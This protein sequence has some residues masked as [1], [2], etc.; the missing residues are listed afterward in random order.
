MRKFQFVVKF[1]THQILTPWN[2]RRGQPSAPKNLFL[3]NWTFIVA[4]SSSSISPQNDLSRFKVLHGKTKS[5][6]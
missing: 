2:R 6:L 1:P 5:K 3:T 4:F